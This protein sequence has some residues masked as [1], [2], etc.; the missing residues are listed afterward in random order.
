M[1]ATVTGTLRS[2][3]GTARLLVVGVFVNNLTS[4]LN[5]FL[6]L[7]LVHRGVSPWQASLALAALM[8]GRVIGSAM[9]GTVCAR[10][11][12]RATIAGSLGAAAVLTV[13]LV[14]LPVAALAIAAAI[15]FATRVG[16]P[17][18]TAWLVELTPAN[19]Q[20]MVFAVQRLAFNLGV[21]LGSLLAAVIVQYSYDLLFYADA[22]TTLAFCLIAV[23]FLPAAGPSVAPVR[24][25]RGG[26]RR[27]WGD[28]RFMV[29]AA[30]LFLV[31]VAY[32]QASAA[33][34]L[35]VTGIGQPAS[36]YALL[37]AVNG[38]VVITLEVL[39]SRW[40]Q[41]LPTWLPMA[42]GMALLGVGEMLYLV[43]GGVPMLV[44]ATL[45]WTLGETVAAPSMLAYPGLVAPADLRT[46]YIS[47]ATAAQ[48]LGCAVGPV[49]GTVLWQVSSSAVWLVTGGCAVL[50]AVPV[51]AGGRVRRVEDL[52][53]F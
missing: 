44:V 35:F 22:V 14:F 10:F 11:G 38:F 51:I 19:Q 27:V 16:L 50:A 32:V 21:T 1:S 36:V 15:G 17:A 30:A 52:V 25:S 33:L 23:V 4:F 34:P 41:S 8:I 18:A 48:Q 2:M 24:A 7:F 40:T 31:A 13:A 9:G 42:L 37:L 12:R 28:T 20:V 29:V 43:P 45:A 26:G 46:H 49:V 47:F 5:A 53:S 6:V 3:T 39:V